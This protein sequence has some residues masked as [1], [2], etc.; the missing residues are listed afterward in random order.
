MAAYAGLVVVSVA[1][2]P[3]V[4]GPALVVVW[5][6]VVGLFVRDPGRVLFA[7]LAVGG[8]AGLLKATTG[9]HGDL[10]GAFTGI[11]ACLAIYVSHDRP[12][13]VPLDEGRSGK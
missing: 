13:S 7:A 1:D 12:P 6:V 11:V 4:V 5:L 2:A 3:E 9:A 10:L 8:A